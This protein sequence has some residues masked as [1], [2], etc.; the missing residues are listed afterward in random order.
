MADM[1]A[2]EHQWFAALVLM[3]TALFIA[4]GLPVAPRWR[5]TFK[6]AAIGGFILGVVAVLVQIA[7]WLVGGGS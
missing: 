1:T 6:A 5:R 2:V 3:A 4:A 7:R